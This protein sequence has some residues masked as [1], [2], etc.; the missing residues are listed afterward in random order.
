MK[1]LF[2]LSAALSIAAVF[3]MANPVVTGNDHGVKKKKENRWEPNAAIEFQ[4]S[5][6]RLQTASPLLGV[7]SLMTFAR[8]P[9][10]GTNY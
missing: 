3:V 1:K 8:I 6:S 10:A 7:K 9:C 4:F 2:C 5:S